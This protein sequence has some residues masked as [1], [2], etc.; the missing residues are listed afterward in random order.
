MEG[1][2]QALAEAGVAFDPRLVVAETASAAD[3]YRAALTLLRAAERP[4][5]LF[6]FA[7]RMAMGVYH[8]AAELGLSIPAD[9]SS[10][11]STTRN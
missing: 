3:A 2:R 1:Y 4:T 8:A 5:A 9:L 7:D 11:G 10:S 6:C